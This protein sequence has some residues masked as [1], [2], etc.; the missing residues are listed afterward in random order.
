[1]KFLSAIMLFCTMLNASLT[2]ASSNHDHDHDSHSDNDAAEHRDHEHTDNQVSIPAALA[3]QAGIRT[4]TATS[5]VL[6]QQV[7][8]FGRL[9]PYPQHIS[10]IRARFPGLIRQVNVQIGESI[11]TGMVIARIEAND[12]LR[13]YD[14][15]SPIDGVVIDRHANAGEFT[16]EDILFTLANYDQLELDLS[17][18]ARDSQRIRIGQDVAIFKSD[19]RTGPVIAQGN[20]TYITAGDGDTPTVTAHVPLDNTEQQLMAGALV[21]ALV[22]VAQDE[23]AVLIEKRAVQRHDGQAVVFV[24]EGNNYTAR[25]VILGRSN[26]QSVEVLS[27]LQAGE[28]YVVDNSFLVKADLEKSGAAHVH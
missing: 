3:S 9:K 6:Q 24:Q 14:I 27:G 11:K 18:F 1:M 4:Q 17:I 26:A 10:H 12:S 8:L 25:A 20:I 28:D 22:T 16:G 15:T 23:V 19:S 5:G 21:E 7:L 2:L 13:V